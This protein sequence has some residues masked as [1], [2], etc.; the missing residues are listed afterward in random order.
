M[1]TEVEGGKGRT[2]AKRG[3]VQT[4]KEVTEP[5][6]RITQQLVQKHFLKVQAALNQF[7]ISVEKELEYLVR[8]IK[9]K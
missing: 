9:E 3:R 6:I 5:Q 1:E 8:T 7:P 4:R 2:N